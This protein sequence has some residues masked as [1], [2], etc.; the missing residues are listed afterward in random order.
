MKILET[1]QKILRFRNYSERTI[2]TYSCYLKKFFEEDRIKDPYQV[3]TRYI[4]NYLINRSYSSNSQQ[5]QIIG[6]LKLFAK[7]ILKKKARNLSKIERPRKEKKIPMVL[8]AEMLA[9]KIK[10]IDNLKH[11]LIL[12]L[13]LSCGLRVSEVVN[14]KWS[15]I[16]R[17]RNVINIIR[18]K[19]NKD[20]PVYLN[21]DIIKLLEDYWYKYKSKEYVLNGQFSNQYSTSSIQKIVKKHIHPKASFHLLRHSFATYAHE[22]GNDIAVLSKSLGHNS[23]KTTMI[24]THISNNSLKNIKQ[25]I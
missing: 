10:K 3:T 24:Y 7:Y 25:A 17:D 12:S 2:E 16:N 13:G 23:I 14:L 9:D 8:D 15:N 4:E 18:A 21:D 19:G 1:Y 22:Q 20:R 5:N 6:S 11:R